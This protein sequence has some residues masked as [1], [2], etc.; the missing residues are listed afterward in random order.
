[1]RKNKK[2]SGRSRFNRKKI[3]N[4][5]H[6]STDKVV[7]HFSDN[8]L[9]R[10]KNVH[11]VRLWVIE[12]ALLVLSVFLFSIVQ[13]MWYGDSYTTEA[14]VSGGN[15][16]EAVI[17]EVNSMNPLYATTNAEKT[18]GKLMFANLVSPDASG[19]IKAELAKSVRMDKTGQVWTVTLKDKIFWSDGEPITADDV[20]FTTNLI[21]DP[22][23]KTT[24]SSDFSNVAIK[25]ID[26]KTVE[27]KLPSTYI[28]FEDTLEFPLIPAHI[29]GEVSPALVFE[30]EYSMKPV[31]SGPF[32]LNATQLA[33][34]MTTNTRTIYLSR[35]ENYFLSNTKLDTFTVKTYKSQ[36]DIIDALNA[37]EVTATA[38][39]GVESLDKM[40]D[41]ISSRDS[42]LNGGAFAFLNTKSDK[43]KSREVRQAIRRGVDIEKLR[44]DI[45]ES[46]RLDYPIL[47][48]QEDLEYPAIEKY[49]LEAAKELIS[50]GGYSYNK[51]GKIVDKDKMPV[52]LN[53]AVQKKDLLTKMAEGFTDELKKL[54][55]EVTLNI[56]DET[57]TAADFFS[58]IVRPRDFDILFY[59][60]SF[61]VSADPFVYY[62]ST[63]ATV[64]GWNFSNYA[65]YFKHIA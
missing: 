58:S 41:K 5:Y 21:R 49:D 34:E 16:T 39:L 42:L 44:A 7:N 29:L 23:A 28:D 32:K 65:N 52:V 62:S 11:E 3:T 27:F 54:G 64:G 6:E 17:G 33:N 15:Y 20:I 43:L 47:K 51:D 19:H 56:Y 61:G 12:W 48:S 10:I 2:K 57:Q 1:M 4:L 46:Q 53:V 63:Q 31:V 22:S 26:D 59:E 24:I 40:S 50:K 8:F 14:Y 45:D 13:I 9:S 36:A 25:K 60:V 30:N 37:S 38:E 55:F 35:N 18:L